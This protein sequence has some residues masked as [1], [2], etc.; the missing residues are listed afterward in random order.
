MFGFEKIE[1]DTRKL[2]YGFPIIFVG[3]KDD[4]FKYNATT[5]SSTYSLGDTIMIGLDANGTA[6]KHI[7]KYKQFS[8]NVPDEKLMTEIEICGLFSGHNRLQ[9]ADMPYTLGEVTDT[10]L[11]DECFLSMECT[12]T[13]LIESGDYLHVLGEIKRRVIA[14]ELVNEKGEVIGEQLSS[15]SFIGDSSKRVYRFY[16]EDSSTLGDFVENG[17]TNCG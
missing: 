11:I 15:V 1:L 17:S 10:P 13:Q 7:R 14:K 2:Y 6:A 9:Q 5:N 4:K 3:Y 8:I 12:V 16:K